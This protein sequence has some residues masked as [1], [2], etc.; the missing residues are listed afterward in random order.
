MKLKDLERLLRGSV[1]FK[2]QA[3]VEDRIET[4]DEVLIYEIKYLPSGLLKREVLQIDLDTNVI[5]LDKINEE[6]AV[7]RYVEIDSLQSV[8]DYKESFLNIKY[9]DSN[10]I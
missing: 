10:L 5:F 3:R 2:L 7:K 9:E 8:D 4:L 1:K 6:E